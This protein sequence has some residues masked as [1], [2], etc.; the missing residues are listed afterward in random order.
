MAP[1]VTFNHF[2]S[3]HWFA[4]RGGWLDPGAPAL[5]AR[6]CDRVMAAF[7]DRIAIAVTLN[8]PDL[9]RMLTWAHLPDF[10][11]DLERA[12]L[13]AAGGAAGVP[14]YRLSNVVVPEE[15]DAIGDGMAAGHRAA[16]G[17]HQG[18]PPRPSGRLLG[19]AGRRPGGRRRPLGPRP[20]ACRGLPAV[21][22]PGAGGRRRRGPELRTHLVRRAGCGRRH[23]PVLRRR[24][25]LPRRGGPLRAR[26]DRP[27]GARDR[28]RDGDPRRRAL[29]PR[30][31][32]GRCGG[33]STP[34]TTG[35]RCGVTSTGR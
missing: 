13:V 24:R 9:P 4:M 21:A 26:G 15:M 20:Q 7:G 22:R 2:T 16:P 30:S 5:F 35:C 14:R 27:A 29:G 10:V 34:S 6:Y 31:S 33:C 32:R 12:T 3:P 25:T 28:A 23:R 11:R 8:E 17:G 18:A 19:R 1:V